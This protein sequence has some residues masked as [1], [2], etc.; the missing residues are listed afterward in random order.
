MDYQAEYLIKLFKK[1]VPRIIGN[2][3]YNKSQKREKQLPVKK[4]LTSKHS[5]VAKDYKHCLTPNLVPDL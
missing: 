3:D 5:M 1:A 2:G 4:A